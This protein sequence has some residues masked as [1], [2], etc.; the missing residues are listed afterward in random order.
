MGCQI[1][2]SSPQILGR[3]PTRKPPH[4]YSSSSSSFEPKVRITSPI[5]LSSSYKNQNQPPPISTATLTQTQPSKTDIYSIKFRTLGACKL[6][7]SRYPDFE[8]NAEGGKGTGT[9][10]KIL[11]KDFNDEISV[12]FD[13]ET[14]YIPPLTTATTKFLGLPLPPFLR[15]D[16][17]PE[18]FRGII[19]QDSGKVHHC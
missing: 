11:T 14:L 10:T 4:L 16:I 8:Y 2:N 7:I 19:Y 1:Q 15:I 9:G 12:D 18:T 3:T 6:G 17:V 13:V 5:N